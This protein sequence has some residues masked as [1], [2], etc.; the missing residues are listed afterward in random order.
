MKLT[1]ADNGKGFNINNDT[2]GHGINN[3]RNR[4]A[5]IGSSIEVQSN[6]TKGT[7]VTLKLKLKKD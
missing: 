3:I 7:Q 6:S 2:T 1:L 4:A 5:R